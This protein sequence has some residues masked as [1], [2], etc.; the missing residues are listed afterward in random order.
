MSE[1][2]K[3]M[4]I[5]V[6]GVNLN[7]GVYERGLFNDDGTER[8]ANYAAEEQQMFRNANYLPVEG[9]RTITPYYDAAEWNKNNQGVP[10]KIVQYDADKNVIV[11][12]TN[13]STYVASRD[14]FVLNANTAYVRLGFHKWENITTSLTDIEMALYY[15]EDARKEFVE[16]GFGSEA[17]YGVPGNKV[18]LTSPN[19][20]TFTLSVSDDGTLSVTANV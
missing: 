18:F 8:G 11:G 16:Y 17:V 2:V 12:M 15:I 20:T 9:G 4:E 6:P 10:V 3:P 14:G 19:G 7:D 13:M 1:A 5:L